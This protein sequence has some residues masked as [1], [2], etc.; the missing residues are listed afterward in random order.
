V[1]PPLFETFL[2]LGRERVVRRLRA[3]LPVMEASAKLA[4]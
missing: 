4:S 2:V 3:A 1:A